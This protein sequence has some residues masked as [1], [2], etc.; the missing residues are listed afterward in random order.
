[1]EGELKAINAR[2]DAADAKMNAFRNEFKSEL[3]RI[4]DTI[5]AR[6]DAA[7]SK[8]EAFRSGLK[9]LGD[10]NN[11]NFKRLDDKIDALSSQLD[12]QRKLTILEAKVSE[13]E[14]NKH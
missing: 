7:D 9:G 14:K 10:T 12:T 4:E 5:N 1:M 8:T 11:A 13:L 2:L 6:L 3:K